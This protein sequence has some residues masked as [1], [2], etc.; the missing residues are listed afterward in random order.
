MKIIGVDLGTTNSCVYALDE[1]G[2]P[3]L[4]LTSGKYKI[5][6]SVVWA[7]GPDKDVLVG[8]A[9]KVRI[10]QHPAPIIAVKRKMGTTDAVSLGG[11]PIQPHEA[12]AHIL[13]HIKRQV[14]EVLQDQIGGVIV[15][16][17]A[18]FDSA[19]KNDTHRAAI[20]AFFDGDTARAEG[21]IQLQLEPEAA[22]YA[23][24]AED[25]AE[26]LRV[27]VYD[28][29]G[30]TFDVT[31][32]EK[33]RE[34][35]TA[36]KFGGDPH[37]GGDN[38]DDRIA[39]WFLYLLRGGR[40]QALDRL[41]D[42]TRYPAE[43]RYTI[44][45]QVLS[46]DVDALRARLR[47][48]D[49]DLLI[50]PNPPAQLDLDDTKP[51]DL[52]RIQVLKR[53]AE[54]AK[55][56]LTTSPEAVVAKQ[57]AFEDQKG[58]TVDIDLTLSRSDFDRLIGDFVETTVTAVQRVLEESGQ[59]AGTIDR[60]LLVGGSSRMPVVRQTLERL[61]T[62][63]I[64]LS[65]PDLIVARGAALR[66][67]HLNPPPLDGSAGAGL[68]LT[69]P[70]ETFE[71]AID[72]RG[73]LPHDGRGHAYLL[74][75]QREIADAPVSGGAFVLKAIPLQPNRQNRFKIEVVDERENPV[76]DQEIV[77]RHDERAAGGTDR[78]AP[79][80]TQPI[81]ALST[82][83]F[84]QLFA[85]GETLPITK[86]FVCHRATQDDHIDIEFY[87]GNR[88][89]A[90]LHIA[91]VDQRLPIG[92]PIDLEITVAASYAVSA[93][94]VVRETKQTASVTFEI[95]HLKIPSL[96]EMDADMAHALAQIDNDLALVRDVNQRAI[97][98]SRG[99]RLAAEYDKA[100]NAMEKDGHKLFSTI[101]EARKLLIDIRAAQVTL[102]PPIEEFDKAI[103][104]CRGLAK[105]LQP[106]SVA[107]REDVEER[108]NS[109]ERAGHAA[110][111]RED[112]VEWKHVT[113]E[114]RNVLTQ[115]RQAVEEG[116]GG[117]PRRPTPPGQL[118]ADMLEWL[119]EIREQAK[120]HNLLE[121]FAEEAAA[122]ERAIRAVEL[123]DEDRARGALHE[124]LD[125]S[126][127]PLNHRVEKA[128][129]DAG[130][131]HDP[132][133]PKVTF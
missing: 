44:L 76:L 119:G 126:L 64:L 12:S 33:S 19:P 65:D 114:I 46:N 42:G 7:A 133:K 67:L 58:E 28:L 14:E 13:R 79:K 130:G 68:R 111:K 2:Q 51:D 57:G 25:P 124:I 89:L 49:R 47:P 9:A 104:L 6:P 103:Q 40:A 8:H 99:Q 108:V 131:Q 115:L 23:Y 80:V 56:E 100:R 61:F 50:G 93:S 11:T 70:R 96:K 122:T 39:S 123:H 98:A 116:G 106:S 3:Q 4:V 16:V 26:H 81:R 45:Q 29:G 109:L 120:A 117:G 48:D 85:E 94:A 102:S 101:G 1:Q 38:V 66:A 113:N 27:L 88:P 32:L 35:V 31:V 37:L 52:R 41:L 97:F 84:F 34:G 125:K 112:A 91:Q 82:Q 110:W 73:R 69:Y 30:G 60:V 20:D 63:P 54:V 83:G 127:R 87:E 24:A 74:D 71:D 21:R 36:L 75:D 62:C 105:H 121:H 128:I 53:L 132:R 59:T 18:Y 55:I 72:I 92:A 43:S 90:S 17:P 77:I 129:A 78:L 10:G 107:T 95:T 15:T 118:R 5:F 22:A 86:P